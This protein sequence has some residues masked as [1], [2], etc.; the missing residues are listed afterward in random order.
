VSELQ[1]RKDRVGECTGRLY[2]VRSPL[3][4]YLRCMVQPPVHLDC[5]TATFPVFMWGLVRCV[6]MRA[7][8]HL[9]TLSTASFRLIHAVPIP[10]PLTHTLLHV[11]PTV[12]S[13]VCPLHLSL[14]HPST[15][16]WTRLLSLQPAP[17]AALA[18][19]TTVE[20]RA[21]IQA[22]ADQAEALAARAPSVSTGT[23][24][25]THAPL[26]RGPA[27]RPAAMGQG[28]CQLGRN[29]APRPV[30]AIGQGRCRQ[31]CLQ[32]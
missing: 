7:R 32:S 12:C 25:V 29:P 19:A 15:H 20:I 3:W 21:R 18:N 4:L 23:P 2:R 14:T 27:L 17:K 13:S 10:V 11:H 22:D 1:L 30:V 31:R 9:Q 26:D 24:M 5:D 6:F 16:P 8:Q 28:R